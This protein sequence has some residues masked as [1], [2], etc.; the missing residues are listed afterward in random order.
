MFGRDPEK[1]KAKA[2]QR[3]SAEIRRNDREGRAALDARPENRTITAWHSAPPR[4]H[5]WQSS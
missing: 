3:R 1:A 5:W 2:R 4:R